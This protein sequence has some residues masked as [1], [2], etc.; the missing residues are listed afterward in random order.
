MKLAELTDTFPNV[1]LSNY[2]Y[3]KNYLI[4]VLGG[5]LL[6]RNSVQPDGEI[7]ILIS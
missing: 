2:I 3:F 1:I 7:G 4:L 5:R 6:R